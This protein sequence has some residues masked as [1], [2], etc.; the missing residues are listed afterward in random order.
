VVGSTIG[1]RTRF[2]QTKFNHWKVD[3]KAIGVQMALFA[4]EYPL[5]DGTNYSS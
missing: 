1:I 4:I 2:L 5:F 3:P